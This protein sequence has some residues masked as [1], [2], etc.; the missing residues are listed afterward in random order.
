MH[1]IV[2]RILADLAGR[3]ALGVRMIDP[4]DHVVGTCVLALW[5]IA[6]VAS[7][8]KKRLG[9]R[10]ISGNL[11]D[12]SAGT[13]FL[14]AMYDEDRARA[15]AVG[16]VQGF[17]ERA[18]FE[19]LVD[20]GGIWFECRIRNSTRWISKGKQWPPSLRS[21]FHRHPQCKKRPEDS[22]AVLV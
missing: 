11:I 21:R 17:S 4:G 6:L 5:R 13:G 9:G 1:D 7:L 22:V 3:T 8:S 2:G 16:C 14:S 12:D 15:V 19:I 10:V 18:N 20:E